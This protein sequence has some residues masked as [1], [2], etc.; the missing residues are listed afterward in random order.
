MS[1]CRTVALLTYRQGGPAVYNTQN[2]AGSRP[3]IS[4]EGLQEICCVARAS[5]DGRR[6]YHVSSLS[7]GW[8]GPATAGPLHC[9]AGAIT[10]PVVRGGVGAASGPATSQS[11]PN[12][13]P[14]H[15]SHGHRDTACCKLQEGIAG[16][17]GRGRMLLVRL[18]F[19]S[20]LSWP[21]HL[22][23]LLLAA[24]LG[25]R[26]PARSVCHHKTHSLLLRLNIVLDC[27]GEVSKCQNILFLG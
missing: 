7:S 9:A 16:L 26:Q 3:E 19:S 27:Q 21:A 2:N 11:R 20:L 6:V 4:R 8:R 12:T 14:S 15:T 24:V 23:R 22:A 25:H 13:L 17:R 1:H 5:C 10:V 18:L